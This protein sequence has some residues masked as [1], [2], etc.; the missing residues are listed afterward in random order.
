[1]RLPDY[2]SGLRWVS[3]RVVLHSRRRNALSPS[4]QLRA[5]S[6]GFLLE[7]PAVHVTV[8]DPLQREDCGPARQVGTTPMDRGNTR[9]EEYADMRGVG[10]VA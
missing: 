4:H 9:T 5:S 10:S 7:K 6:G 1:M 2:A 8:K 3:W